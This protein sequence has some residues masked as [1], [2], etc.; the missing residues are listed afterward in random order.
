MKYLFSKILYDFA[1]KES[2]WSCRLV[3]FACM[4]DDGR[5]LYRSMSL[6]WNS[7]DSTEEALAR[8]LFREA[9]DGTNYSSFELAKW[10]SDYTEALEKLQ[11]MKAEC[12]NAITHVYCVRV[13]G[14]FAQD[15]TI[16][17]LPVTERGIVYKENGKTAYAACPVE[18]G[19]TFLDQG[20][21]SKPNPC[22]IFYSPEKALTH[23]T[24]RTEDRVSFVE[25]KYI[26]R[27]QEAEAPR[28][29]KLDLSEPEQFEKWAACLDGEQKILLQRVL[30]NDKE[31]NGTLYF[32]EE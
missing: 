30:E 32:E 5:R 14:M 1:G 29:V 24:E 20:A 31:L 25:G 26:S 9:E 7:S 17:K 28:L 8:R 12:D 18:G 27:F 4:E 10:Y 3:P 11:G 21:R 22:R 15:V 6:S 13:V 23:A 2:P 19:L 16:A